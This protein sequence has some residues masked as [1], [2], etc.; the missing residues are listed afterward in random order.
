MGT[1]NSPIHFEHAVKGDRGIYFVSRHIVYCF[2]F[3]HQESLAN[4]QLH[5]VLPSSR[6]PS[7]LARVLFEMSLQRV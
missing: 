2:I 6:V 1:I 4:G 7:C 5:R 3:G